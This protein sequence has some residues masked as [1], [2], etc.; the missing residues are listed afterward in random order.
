[1]L[2]FKHYFVFWCC[3]LLSACG[4]QPLYGTKSTGQVITDFATVQVAPM[5]DRIGQ[6]LH[7]QLEQL[8]H[9]RGAAPRYS[10][11]LDATLKE[12]TTSLAVKKSAFATR[13]NLTV[14]VTYSLA[15][16]SERKSVVHASNSISVSYNIF[17]SEFETL[18]AEKD[19]RTRAVRELAQ[20]IR[21]RLGVFLRAN[22]NKLP[23]SS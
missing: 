21:I 11:R 3:L 15:S 10:Y 5:R 9:P 6:Q 18:V 13:A 20:E 12:T 19:A 17:D 22:K 16:L 14:S 1:M 7:N 2:L 23:R 8:L 4:F